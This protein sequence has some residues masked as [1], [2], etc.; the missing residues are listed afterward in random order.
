M[1]ASPMSLFEKF[2]KEAYGSQYVIP[3]YQRN[4]TWKKNKQVKQLLFDIERILKGETKR[5][6]IG[7]IVY[8]ITNTDFIVRE[9][10]VVDGQQRLITMFLIAY[11]LKN[12]TEEKGETE[13]SKI[14][15]TNYLE[16]ANQDKYKYRLQPAVSDDDAYSHITEGTIDEYEGSSI[17]MDNYKYIYNRLI[18]LVNKYSSMRV[19]NAL[20]ELYIVRIELDETDDAQQIFESINST[21]EKL[22]AADLIRN[23]IMMNKTNDIQETIYNKYWLKLEHIFPQ[24][25]KLAEFIRLYLASKSYILVTERDLYEEF[26]NYWNE[27]LSSSDFNAILTEMLNYAKHFQRLY[28]KNTI[29]ELGDVLKDYR[30]LQSLMPAPFT[31][32][33]LDYYQNNCISK[34]QTIAVLK[35]I[36]TY[37]VR[38]YINGQDTSA[39]SRFFPGFLKNVQ[40]QLAKDGHY[41][42]IVDICIYYLININK[43]KASFMPD[44]KQLRDYLLTANAYSLANIRWILDKIETHNNPVSVDLEMLNIEHIMPQT[45]NVYWKEVSGLD[46]DEYIDIA[47]RL[48]NLTLA[49]IT[50]NSKMGNK[51]FEAKKEILKSTKHLRLNEDILNKKNWRPTD[52]NKRTQ[53][54][55]NEIITI[56]PYVKTTYTLGINE[57][58]RDIFLKAKGIIA[59]GHLNKN[60]SI[61]VYAD[62]QVRFDKKPS[63][64][65][66]REKRDEY[67]EQEILINKDGKYLFSQD[68][69]FKTPSAAADFILGGSNNG[70]LYWKDSNGISINESLRNKN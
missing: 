17:V 6:F 3:V 44:D 52:I 28:I 50:D 64:E 39:I 24:S 5:H 34:E 40:N 53:K 7:T 4:Y 65:A 62:S 55:T 32:C 18:D 38:R 2:I 9:R 12:I 30:K 45:P 23:Y 37:L 31:M 56:F 36:N 8:V 69:T 35:I 1:E 10:V 42:K 59:H 61:T 66:L 26:K 11:A 57:Q 20:R 58:K 46:D 60:N 22:T 70:W 29:D 67:L 63:N 47:N 49:A 19:I 51:D 25:R 33:L 27:R 13:L 54:I 16:N 43:G 21:G 48:G 68:F 41:D 14:L 15:V